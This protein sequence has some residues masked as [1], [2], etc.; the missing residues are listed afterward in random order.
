M[1][2]ML[3]KARWYYCKAEQDG[4]VVVQSNIEGNIVRQGKMVL[5]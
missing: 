2:V 5:L 3:G 1:V 4:S